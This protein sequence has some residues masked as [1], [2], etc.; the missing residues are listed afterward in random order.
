MVVDAV[1]EGRRAEVS[2]FGWWFGG[3]DDGGSCCSEV[4]I[5]W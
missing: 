3:G 2:Q 5:C 1:V 4:K